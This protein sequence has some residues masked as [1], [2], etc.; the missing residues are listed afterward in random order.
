[1]FAVS[2]LQPSTAADGIISHS[3][4]VFF[5]WLW[6]A[7]DWAH[8][9]LEGCSVFKSMGSISAW[10]ALQHYCVWAVLAW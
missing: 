7:G 6:G 5:L 4:S 2:A 3:Y 10:R 9:R 8:V 1:V